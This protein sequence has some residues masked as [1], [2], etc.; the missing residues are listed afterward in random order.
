MISARLFC[1]KRHSETMNFMG[2]FYGIEHE[3]CACAAGIA[4]NGRGDASFAAL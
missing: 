4:I 1:G 3:Q 2:L